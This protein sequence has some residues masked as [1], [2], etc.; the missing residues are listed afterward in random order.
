MIEKTR[1][2][3]NELLK[4]EG[5]GHGMDHVDRVFKLAM[6]FAENETCNKEIVAL[7]A[8]LHDVDD[9]KLFGGNA[10]GE[11]PNA[12]RI[13]N[14]LDIENQTKTHVLNIIQNMGYSKYL[15][16]IRP[17]TIEGMI[18]SDADMCDAIGASGILRTHKYN[19]KHGGE[20]FNK[21]IWPVEEFSSKAYMESQPSTAV[22]HMFEKM[23][24]L[25]AIMMT[26]VGKKEAQKRHNLMVDFLRQLFDEENVPEWQEYLDKYLSNF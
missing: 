4:N 11:L 22:C 18:V 16:G 3:V 15:K 23:L 6:E 13:L 20:F 8:L 1:E 5:S 12:S 14:E 2:Y 19:I 10:E 25:K 21:N 9:Y 24:K 7:A 17:K 26:E